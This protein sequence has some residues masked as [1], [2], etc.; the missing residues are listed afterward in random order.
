MLFIKVYPHLTAHAPSLFLPLLTLS[1]T[2][3]A[4]PNHSAW[5]GEEK[6][7]RSIRAVR[8]SS[9]LETEDSAR[10]ATSKKQKQRAQTVGVSG[11]SRENTDLNVGIRISFF[12]LGER[13]LHLCVL[14]K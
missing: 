3:Q 13:R 9:S 11:R 7:R 1:P 14:P 12:L 10:V 6:W 5:D 2:E 4:N 8:R